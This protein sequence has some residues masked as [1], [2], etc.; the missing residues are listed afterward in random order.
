MRAR[1]LTKR[2][3]SRARPLSPSLARPL[4][5]SYDEKSDVF[6]FAMLMWEVLHRELPFCKANG[7]QVLLEIHNGSRPRIAL[8]PPL[9]D[10]GALIGRCWQQL[11]EC[12]PRMDEVMRDLEQ[13]SLAPSSED[14]KA[15]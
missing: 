5:R 7:M 4:A 2:F 15:A 12:R 14:T 6:S 1:P 9:A 10:L 13:I 11:P 3:L 8:P